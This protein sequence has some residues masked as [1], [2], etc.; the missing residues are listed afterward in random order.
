[1]DTEASLSAVPEELVRNHEVCGRVRILDANGGSKLRNKVRAFVL[2]GEKANR[3][4]CVST[5]N[6]IDA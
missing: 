5:S 3:Y 4:V 6:Y 2:F 1:M